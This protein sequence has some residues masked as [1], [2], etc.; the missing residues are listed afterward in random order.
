MVVYCE[1]NVNQAYNFLGKMK[2]Y[3]S[4]DVCNNKLLL[5]FWCPMYIR[6][7]LYILF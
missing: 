2:R 3:Q 5:S 6:F 7:I 4:G 1:N